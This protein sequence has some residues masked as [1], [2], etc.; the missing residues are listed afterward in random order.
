MQRPA[1]CEDLVRQLRETHAHLSKIE[2]AKL[3]GRD[4]RVVLVSVEATAPEHVHH[5]IV[6]ARWT[7]EGWKLAL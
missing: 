5:W 7:A 6:R 4:K 3:D 2:D 1:L